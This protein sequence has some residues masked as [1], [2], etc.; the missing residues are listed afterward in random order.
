[1]LSGQQ[2]STWVDGPEYEMNYIH[3]NTGKYPAVRGLDM[4]DSPDFASRAIGW[5]NAGGIPMVGLRN[6]VWL[7]PFNG[8]PDASFYPGKA[9]VDIGGADT[10]ASDHGPLLPM[11]N[12]AR[13]LV[14]DTIPI[15]LLQRAHGRSSV[16]TRD[17]VPDLR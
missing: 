2:E 14:G 15:S 12:I 13:G 5:W 11:F 3:R 17:E 1:M 6:L 8:E 4:G 7:H 16:V 9:C 10:Y